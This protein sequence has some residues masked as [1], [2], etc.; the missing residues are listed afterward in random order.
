MGK[1]CV[2]LVK[3]EDKIK[4]GKIIVV[5]PKHGYEI[6]VEGGWTRGRR[7]IA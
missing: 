3:L 6:F 1:N 2:F 5:N 4:R 7:G